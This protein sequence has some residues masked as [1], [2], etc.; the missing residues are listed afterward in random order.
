[1]S[2]LQYLITNPSFGIFIVLVGDIVWIIASIIFLTGII[3]KAKRIP[4]M[5]TFWSIPV[6]IIGYGISLVARITDKIISQPIWTIA[7]IASP[8]LLILVIL[9]AIFCLA[10]EIENKKKRE[11]VDAISIGLF[12]LP[13]GVYFIGII[14]RWF[15][16]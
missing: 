16:I 1:M 6:G 12:I 10:K 14:F 4:E 11:F 5:L 15:V 7:D 3:E 13:F 2:Y 9:I 8:V